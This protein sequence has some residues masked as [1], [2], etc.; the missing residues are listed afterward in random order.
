[1]MPGGFSYPVYRLAIIVVGHRAVAAGPVL[2]DNEDPA[3]HPDPRGRKPTA[4]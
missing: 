1:M 4:R 2:A 3:G